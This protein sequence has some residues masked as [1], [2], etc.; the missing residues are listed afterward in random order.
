MKIFRVFL[1]SILLIIAGVGSLYA[2]K[3]VPATPEDIARLKE[4]LLTGKIQIGKTRLSHIQ[5]E[6]GEAE[7]ITDDDKRVTY[8][9][10]D[11]RLS[12]D[13]ERLW[14]SWEYDSFKEPVYTNK[15]DDLRFD[16]ESKELVGK[17][18]TYTMVQRSYGAPTESHETDADGDISVYY[19]GDI[20]MVFENII[21]I[22]S[23]RGSKLAEDKKADGALNSSPVKEVDVKAD[24][25]TPDIVK[26]DEVAAAST[27]G[28]VTP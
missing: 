4:D 21:S 16:L 22:R 3:G 8:D 25:I 14:R 11:L 12:F 19:Y 27:T 10:Q 9:F 20:K 1:C 7:N 18:I 26:S 23:W 28:S 5:S 15:V 17:N 24:E 6:Y 13:R 2:L